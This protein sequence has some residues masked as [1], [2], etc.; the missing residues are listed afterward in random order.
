MPSITVRFLDTMPAGMKFPALACMSGQTDRWKSTTVSFWSDELVRQDYQVT[1]LAEAQNRLFANA[2]A[3]RAKAEAHEAQARHDQ[4]AN[5]RITTGNGM[6]LYQMVVPEFESESILFPQGTK[7]CD[8][9]TDDPKLNLWI[10]GRLFDPAAPSFPIAGFVSASSSSSTPAHVAIRFALRDL[11][12]DEKGPFLLPP[13]PVSQPAP[14]ADQRDRHEALLA[15]VKKGAPITGTLTA[16]GKKHPVRLQLN[17]DE[18]TSEITGWNSTDPQGVKKEVQGRIVDDPVHGPTITL[19]DL[20]PI[21]KTVAYYGIAGFGYFIRLQDNTP[22]SVAVQK[23]TFGDPKTGRNVDVTEKVRAAV[24]GGSLK[25][26]VSK[27]LGDPAPGAVKMLSVDL[28]GADGKLSTVTANEGKI[29]QVDH[30]RS[31]RIGALTG[32]YVCEGLTLSKDNNIVFDD[33]GR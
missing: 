16:F 20:G 14:P 29:L 10:S 15:L 28:L 2:D 33:D 21:D 6:I 7:H 9:A 22:G 3:L 32:S 31:A 11:T 8:I 17:W 19:R 13:M 4:L 23:A 12:G 27:A 5:T 26:R 25:F 30:V 18:S 24:N 1:G